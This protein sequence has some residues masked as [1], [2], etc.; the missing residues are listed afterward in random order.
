MGTW[1][2]GI[3]SDDMASDIRAEF[4]DHIIDGLTPEE[5]T[6]KLIAAYQPESDPEEASVFWL[7]LASTQWS[8]GRLV[9]HVREKASEILASG[10]EL[11]RWQDDAKAYAKRKQVLSKLQEQLASTPPPARKIK[12]K[13]IEINTWTLGAVYSYRLESGRF[14]LFRVVGHEEM[15]EGRFAAIEVLNWSGETPPRKWR[16]RFMRGKPPLKRN[17]HPHLLLMGSGKIPSER[18][19]LLG[20]ASKIPRMRYSSY[21]YNL[22]NMLKYEFGLY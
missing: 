10:I 12:R 17:M 3:F 5:A 15:R 19:Q 7:A 1:G 2:T 6:D 14:C 13:I 8:L 9:P 22:D 16:I 4:R 21:A 11:T 18:L 20:V